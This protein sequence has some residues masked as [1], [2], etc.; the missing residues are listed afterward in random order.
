MNIFGILCTSAEAQNF[1]EGQGHTGIGVAC[2][3][4]RIR[5]LIWFECSTNFGQYM[6]V[7]Y[8]NTVFFNKEH[9]KI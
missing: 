5:S 2:T 7:K 1:A 8:H 4:S 9:R 6:H 3:R